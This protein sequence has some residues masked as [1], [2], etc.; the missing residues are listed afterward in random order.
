M[1]I[2]FRTISAQLSQPLVVRI[3]HDID[4]P[5]ANQGG[6]HMV[7]KG[8]LVDVVHVAVEVWREPDILANNLLCVLD[9][10]PVRVL[11]SLNTPAA[12]TP[13][14]GLLRKRERNP[15]LQRTGDESALAVARAAR[16]SDAG[17]VDAR[18]RLG[19]LQGVHDAG[20]TP[21]PGG[22]RTGTVRAP[23]QVVELTLSAARAVLLSRHA[24]VVEQDG[25]HA[26]GDRDAGASGAV[27]DDGGERP[28]PA[29]LV[30][31]DR[32]GNGLSA[33]RHRD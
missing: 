18:L 31:G 24:V 19:Q 15:R 9:T 7:V 11:P 6:Q 21:R 1:T 17:R 20:D 22:Q 16:H 23:V 14:A 30:D 26:R 10:I 27:V 32:E 25:R 13:R 5:R 8:Q 3:L 12:R 33:I 28:R 29:R 2:S 4:G